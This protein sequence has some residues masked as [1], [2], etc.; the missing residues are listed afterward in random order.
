[1]TILSTLQKAYDKQYPVRIEWIDIVN[2]TG[3]QN[4]KEDKEPP[5]ECITYGFITGIKPYKKRL[6]IITS[7]TASRYNDNTSPT[8]YISHLTIPIDV[9][10]KVTKI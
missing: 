4:L 3:W 7:S 2:W 10:S 6:C 1:M 5:S 9:I 8:E